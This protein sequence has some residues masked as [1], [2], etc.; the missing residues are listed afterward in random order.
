M[1]KD[2]TT[3]VYTPVECEPSEV[4][5]SIV[6]CGLHILKYTQTKDQMD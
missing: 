5:I 4:V 3:W 2:G 1:Q 6:H